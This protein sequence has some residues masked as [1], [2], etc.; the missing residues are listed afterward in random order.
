MSF[1]TLLPLFRVLLFP[2][3][4]CTDPEEIENGTVSFSTR[5]IDSVA[6]YECD[7]GFRLEGVTTRTCVRNSSTTAVWSPEA[8]TCERMY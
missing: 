5:T 3:V 1:C 7:D 4:Q 8:P 6:R 2:S